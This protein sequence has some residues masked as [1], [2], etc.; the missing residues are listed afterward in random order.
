MSTKEAIPDIAG[1]LKVANK[2]VIVAI[3][4]AMCS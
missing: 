4:Y 2:T 3:H 1:A